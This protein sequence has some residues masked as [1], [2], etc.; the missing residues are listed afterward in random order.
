[1]SL[2]L[3]YDPQR[4][5]QTLGGVTVTGFVEGSKVTVSKADGVTSTTRGIENDLSININNMKDGTVSFSLLHNHPFNRTMMTWANCY[6]QKTGP[7]YLPY[8]LNDPSGVALTTIAWLETMPDYTAGMETGEL[9]WTLHVQD[10]N[11]QPSQQFSLASAASVFSGINLG[12]VIN[13]IL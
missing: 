4:V 13:N 2:P 10:A 9:T 8:N 7:Y 12:S 1:M 5:T 6:Q 11:I 3:V